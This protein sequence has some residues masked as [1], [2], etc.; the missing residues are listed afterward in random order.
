MAVLTQRRQVVNLAPV[1]IETVGQPVCTTPPGARNL[2]RKNFHW[3]T[4][5]EISSACVVFL[6][7]AE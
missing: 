6:D 5:L 4:K 2:F 1:A 3:R 7:P